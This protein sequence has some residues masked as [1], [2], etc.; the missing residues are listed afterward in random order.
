M[1]SGKSLVKRNKG[2]MAWFLQRVTA[3]Y[4]F[5][6]L[7]AHF[8]I[9]HFVGT[10]EVTYETVAP[11]L[12]SPLWK[13]GDLLF[14]LFALYHGINGLWQVLEDYIRGRGLRLFLYAVVL[15]IAVVLLVVG[16]IT[17]FSVNPVK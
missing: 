12:S 6:F 11:R 3:L 1:G 16:T 5:V 2:A 9:M 4:L 14:L 17:I 8:V 13:A 15:T 7:I 10:G